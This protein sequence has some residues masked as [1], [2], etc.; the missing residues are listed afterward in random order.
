MDCSTPG[1]P[2]LHYLPEFA[3]TPVHGVSDAIQ[4]SHLL[5]PPSPPTLNLFQ[6]QGFS[7]ESVLRIRWPKYWSFSFSISPSSE[8]SEL[9]SFRI[10]WFDL[11]GPAFSLSSFTIKRLFNSSSDSSPITSNK[12]TTI[13]PNRKTSVTDPNRK[14]PTL[15]WQEVPLFHY[16]SRKKEDFLPVLQQVQPIRDCCHLNFYFPP[17]NLNFFPC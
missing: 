12:K 1:F 13:T 2:V 15:H 16:C 3:Q 17:M 5:S 11:L 10:G 6:H 7:K 14:I 8:Y 9:I 4:P